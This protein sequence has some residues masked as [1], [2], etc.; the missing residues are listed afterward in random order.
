MKAEWLLKA[1]NA[2]CDF[3]GG[4]FYGLNYAKQANHKHA[5]PDE[6]CCKNFVNSALRTC[7]NEQA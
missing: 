7:E 5:E 2:R 1:S 4:I 6:D 3:I